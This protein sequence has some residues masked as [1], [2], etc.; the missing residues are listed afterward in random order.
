MKTIPLLIL[1]LLLF[2]C[3]EKE[4]A[5]QI[6]KE[7]FTPYFSLLKN[8]RYREAYETYTSDKYKKYNFLADFENSYTENVNRRGPLESH[9]IRLTRYLATIFGEDEVRS[10]VFLQFQKENNAKP[11]LY[12]LSEGGDGKFYIDSGWH[13]TKYA[14][15]DGFDGPF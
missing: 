12:I 7:V 6:E 13:H 9:E 1:T 14:A 15:P 3:N 10:E 11:V 4:V 2:G 5:D 8:E